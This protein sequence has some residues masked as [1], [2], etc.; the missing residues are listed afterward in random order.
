MLL[1]ERLNGSS[2]IDSKPVLF[3]IPRNISGRTWLNEFAQAI[4]PAFDK[5][6]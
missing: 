1:L 2:V 5:W 3:S 4:D 6:L